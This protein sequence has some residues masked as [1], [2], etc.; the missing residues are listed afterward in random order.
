MSF[1]WP[2]TSLHLNAHT[3]LDRLPTQYLVDELSHGEVEAGLC[4]Y[5]C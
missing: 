5:V 3:L 1:P 2:Q 4:L